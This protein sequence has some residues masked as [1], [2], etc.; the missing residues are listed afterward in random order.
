[1]IGGF[2]NIFSYFKIGAQ[3]QDLLVKASNESQIHDPAYTWD[4]KNIAEGIILDEYT[5]QE[6]QDAYTSAWYVM[7]QSIAA[8]KDLGLSDRFS[9]QMIEKIGKYLSSNKPLVERVDLNHNIKVHLFSY[10]RQIVSFTDS[11]VSI[12]KRLKETRSMNEQMIYDTLSFDIVMGLEDGYWKVFELLQLKSNP[13]DSFKD[14]EAKNIIPEN[15]KGV[16]YYPSANPWL[17]FWRNYNPEVVKKD[18]ALI[19]HYK[20]N[21]LRIFIPYAIFG[22]GTLNKKMIAKLDSFL[23]I[24][25]ENKLG[26]TLTLFDFPESYRLAYYPSTRKHL[27]QLLDRYKNHPAVLVWDFKNEPDLDFKHYNQSIVL[28]WLDFILKVSEEY[29]PEIITTIGW[30]DPIYSHHF[31]DELDIV[32]Y[33]M[34]GDINKQRSHLRQLKEKIGNDKLIY[35]SEFG[36]TSFQSKFLPFGSTE[37]EQAI[38]VKE[39]LS[40]IQNEKIPHYAFWTLHDFKKAPKEIIGWKPWIRK[41]QENMGLIN[42]NGKEKLVAGNFNGQKE[43]IERLYWYEKIKPFYIIFCSI[44]IILYLINIKFDF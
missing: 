25:D 24:C 18:I 22:K 37:K 1:M 28:D 42:G 36:T 35:I 20:F 44:L 23:H 10:D 12:I 38:Y 13:V 8:G 11:K 5:R 40:F 17:N 2:A 4:I 41:A 3:K 21:H 34:Y 16:N 43:K 27:I 7:N 32:S 9:V 15:L 26:V 31:A 33:H 14:E 6:I 39:A 30:S 29:A 19:K